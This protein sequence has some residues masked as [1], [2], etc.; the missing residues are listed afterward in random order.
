M[1][2]YQIRHNKKT[3]S[4]CSKFVNNNI[5]MSDDLEIANHFNNYF[6]NIG[7]VYNSIFFNL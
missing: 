4:K 7:P 2:Y 1:E 6:A 5:T 3:M